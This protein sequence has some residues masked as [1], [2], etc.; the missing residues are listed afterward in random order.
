V[1]GF[2]LVLLR[3]HPTRLTPVPWRFASSAPHTHAIS[4]RVTLA[5]TI[6]QE[7]PD[8]CCQIFYNWFKS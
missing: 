8:S 4:K 6:G 3:F 2:V 7:E 1:Y 5:H